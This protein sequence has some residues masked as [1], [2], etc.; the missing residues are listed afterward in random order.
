MAR[1]INKVILV[2][3]LGRD[4]E[5]RY[6]PSGAAVAN[7]NLATTTVWRDRQSG[8]QREQTEWHSV[9]FFNRL[10]EIAGEFLKKGS[11]VYIEGSL[12]TRKWQS[13]DGIDRY[14]T[15]VIAEEMQI[16]GNRQGTTGIPPNMPMMDDPMAQSFPVRGGANYTGVGGAANGN[17][18]GNYS[19]AVRPVLRD[20]STPAPA[21]H[22]TNNDDSSMGFDDDIPF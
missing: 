15:E 3:N 2:G 7:L 17:G 16:L 12:R 19:S 1:G 20:N 8:E 13:K 9:V 4:P 5:V 21:S 18:G 14:T 6:M 11:Q 22:S 10:A